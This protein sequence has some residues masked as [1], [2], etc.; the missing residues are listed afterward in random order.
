[1]EEALTTLPPN[2]IKDWMEVACKKAVRVW[3][4]ADGN[5]K[6]W[7]ED[8]AILFGLNEEEVLGQP[9]ETLG[10]RHR[11]QKLTSTLIWKLVF[12]E[13]GPLLFEVEKSQTHSPAAD[14]IGYAR[15]D[16]EE[17]M[18]MLFRLSHEWQVE[19]R[20]KDMARALRECFDATSDLQ[21]AQELLIQRVAERLGADHGWL[22]KQDAHTPGT[23][24]QISAETVLGAP[25]KTSAP[26]RQAVS[27][28]LNRFLE[29]LEG[30]TDQATEFRAPP[31]GSGS[32]S[33]PSSFLGI[34]LKHREDEQWALF[35][36]RRS[37]RQPWSE[38]EAALL[39]ELSDL[40]VLTLENEQLNARALQRA[41]YLS[42]ILNS[43]DLGIMVVH[44]NDGVWSVSLVNERFCHFFGG[45]RKEIE[46]K[47]FE[48]VIRAFSPNYRDWNAQAAI[49]ESL[50]ANPEKES[51]DEIILEKPVYRV[52]NRY[53]TPARNQR[54]EIFGRMFFYRD[55]TYD[56]EMEQQ[57][58]HSQKM[59]SI[60][61]LAG[62][63]AHDF[64]NILT[65]LLGYTDLL[66]R[67]MDKESSG[68]SKLIQIEKSANR[69]A[70]LT[71]NLLAFSRR[72]PAL[73]RVFDVNTLVLET[74][75]MLRSSLPA[76]VE[77]ETNLVEGVPS[78]EADETLIQQVLVN[79]IL[80]ARDALP[81]QS[82]VITIS[83]Q[84]GTDLQQEHGGSDQEFVVVEVEDNGVGIPKQ[85]MSRIFEPFYTTKE[86]GK[87][88]G[89]GLAMVY[90]IV[91][92]HK[93]FIEVT[94]APDQ[95]SK[96]S[97]F[98]PGTDKECMV[99]ETAAAFSSDS[100]TN[101]ITVMVVDDEED[102]RMFCESALSEFCSR[103]ITAEDGIK[104]LEIAEKEGP[105]IDLIILDLS[106]PKMSG[107]ECLKKLKELRPDFKVVISS[108]Y[109]LERSADE[110]LKKNA[111][112]FLP[113][114]YSISE[115]SAVV[116]RILD[117]PDS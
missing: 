93:G 84:K 34:S 91:K 83:T 92:Q 67:E 6:H 35:L 31:P 26:D 88:T 76:S 50:F 61:T 86:V 65:T 97:V 41:S 99:Q 10:L 52:L 79:L 113:K 89:L 3:L 44:D 46:G 77:I 40:L 116:Q 62:G 103:V 23:E 30:N 117:L 11:G 48:E 73:L 14:L 51:V 82:G 32:T 90:G 101:E 38:E 102:L 15:H 56:K 20:R 19:Y 115:L 71:G 106:M 47:P 85:V 94:S 98:L 25:P 70:E 110:E 1:M 87:G 53:S 96:F 58:L 78:I 16:D 36:E 27:A 2:A 24:I 68:Y 49:L 28:D 74:S 100:S 37:G 55:I 111:T 21:H 107:A 4:D 33:P 59:E 5:I 114:P 9:L 63:V 29:Q 8:S 112:D 109:N 95:G 13:H 43:S 72:N 64:N 105:N 12:Q 22:C 18:R 108:G 39:N 7:P 57:L 104:A 75:K 17:G 42:N 45:S 60:G 80:N 81:K 54:G 66:K 69:A